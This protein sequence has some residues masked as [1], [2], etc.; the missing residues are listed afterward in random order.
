MSQRRANF[1][2]AFGTNFLS[3]PKAFWKL[4]RRPSVGQASENELH[5]KGVMEISP[6]QRVG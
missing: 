5:A 6:M 2:G 3:T 1:Q 4:A